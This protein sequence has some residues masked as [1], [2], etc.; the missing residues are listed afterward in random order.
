MPHGPDQTTKIRW[1]PNQTTTSNPQARATS[2]KQLGI[3]ETAKAPG[4][5][6]ACLF[7]NAS[8]QPHQQAIPA[9]PVP[10][11]RSALAALPNAIVLDPIEYMLD[12]FVHFI[13]PMLVMPAPMQ[14]FIRICL[15]HKIFTD[16]SRPELGSSPIRTLDALD[17]GRLCFA[18]LSFA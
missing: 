13:A 3:D 8:L 18:R 4:P 10:F 1:V 2:Q 6:T 12:P 15:Y 9:A 5:A 7:S 11:N 14:N 17:C 16:F